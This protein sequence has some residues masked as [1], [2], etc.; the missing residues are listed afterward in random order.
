MHA[1]GFEDDGF[2]EGERVELR[3]H[4]WFFGGCKEVEWF[5]FSAEL[6]L[7]VGKFG[8]VVEDMD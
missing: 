4:G 5:E 3:P 2:E 8:H 7:Q 1:E 6:G